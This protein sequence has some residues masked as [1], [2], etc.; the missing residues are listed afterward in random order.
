[1]LGLFVESRVAGLFSELFLSRVAGRRR[2]VANIFF[3]SSLV[4]GERLLAFIFLRF[5][6]R[7]PLLSLPCPFGETPGAS[8]EPPMPFWRDPQNAGGSVP[9]PVHPS[10]LSRCGKTHT[11]R[12]SSPRYV[13]VLGPCWW[14]WEPLGGVL[15]PPRN[16]LRDLLGPSWQRI[17]LFGIPELQRIIFASIRGSRA[18]RRQELIS[19]ASRGSRAATGWNLFGQFAG[20]GCPL[21]RIIFASS[22]VAPESSG[23]S[24][25]QFLKF[26]KVI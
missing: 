6:G 3:R 26:W 15:G 2:P 18:G 23:I 13:S 8:F 1:M 22:R 17:L 11:A 25:Y 21:A 19:E 9:R 4:E 10:G 20:R 24:G 7:A 14:P 5:A 16:P 12:A